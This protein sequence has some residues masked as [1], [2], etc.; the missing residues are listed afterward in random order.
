MSTETRSETEMEHD[1][2][3]VKAGVLA[4]LAGTVAMTAL[5]LAMGATNVLGGAIPALYGLAP[6]ANL[7]AGLGVH[8]FHGAV[9][10]VI[11]AGIVRAAEIESIRAIALAGVG[12]GVVVWA[13][14]AALVMPQWLAAVGFPQA[15]PFPNFAPPSLLWH[16]VYG[17][18]AGAVL[19][20]VRGL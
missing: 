16:L 1:G 18:V 6:P 20:A 12:Y 5:M 4:G 7:P 8:A 9:L 17:G 15:P 14:L 13:L 10:G 3:V 19:P 2:G 11:F